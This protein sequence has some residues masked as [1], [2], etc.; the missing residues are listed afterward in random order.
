M[1]SKILVPIDTSRHNDYWL[2]APL[3]TA[4]EIAKTTSGASIHLMSAIPYHFFEGYYPNIYRHE[5]AEETKEELKAIAERYCPRDTKV[6]VC[7][8]EGGTISSDILKAAHERSIDLIVM[9]SHKPMAKDY[10]FGSHA[11]HIA[12]HAPCSVFV[13]RGES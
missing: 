4:V 7:V 13:V 11:G 10:L 3:E 8:E 1:Y 9:A 12:L 6:E 2:K 5:I